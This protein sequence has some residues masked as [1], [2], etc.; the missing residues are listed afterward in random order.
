MTPL[1]DWFEPKASG[2]GWIPKSKEA[3]LLTAAIVVVGALVGRVA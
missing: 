1:R 2:L 3:W